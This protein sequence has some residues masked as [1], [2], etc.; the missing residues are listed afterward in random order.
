MQMCSYEII[1]L[2]TLQHGKRLNGKPYHN[3]IVVTNHFDRM[4]WHPFGQR[5]KITVI[6]KQL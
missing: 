3:I 4:V 5:T 2:I 1:I 6:P